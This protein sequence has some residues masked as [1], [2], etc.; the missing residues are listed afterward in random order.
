MDNVAESWCFDKIEWQS[1]DANKLQ[2]IKVHLLWSGAV[3]APFIGF[4]NW[5]LK[6]KFKKYLPQK[7]Q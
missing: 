3:F 2:E 4:L 7:I 1:I 5:N 6:L